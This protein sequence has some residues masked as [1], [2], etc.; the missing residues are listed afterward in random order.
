[1]LIDENAYDFGLRLSELRKKRGLTQEE[2]AKRLHVH[3][4]TISGYENNISKPTI[5]TLVKLAYIYNTSTDFILGIKNDA[6]NININDLPIHKQ[7]MI[8][9]IINCIRDDYEF[10]NKKEMPK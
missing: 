7:N 4:N 10:E 3:K 1:M 9:K 5:D 2:V 8:K 6:E